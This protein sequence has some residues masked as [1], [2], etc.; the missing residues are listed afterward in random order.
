MRFHRIL[1]S[2]LAVTSKDQVQGFAVKFIESQ[3]QSFHTRPVATFHEEVTS[4]FELVVILQF[5]IV[6]RLHLI[7]T[8]PKSISVSITVQAA[9][10]AHTHT[11]YEKSTIFQLVTVEVNVTCDV[12]VSV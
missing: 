1:P 9:H 8:V 10:D 5:V 2:A 3:S 12:P 4:I 11:P 6:N 7:G